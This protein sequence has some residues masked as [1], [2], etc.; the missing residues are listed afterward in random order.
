MRNLRKTTIHLW[1]LCLLM[2]FILSVT[3]AC[4][5]QSD[6]SGSPL[7]QKINID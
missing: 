2:S 7:P 6:S 3:F 1:I 5:K 4:S